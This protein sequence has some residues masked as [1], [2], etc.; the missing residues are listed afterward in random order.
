MFWVHDLEKKASV[1]SCMKLQTWRMKKAA[2]V[3]HAHGGAAIYI[4]S[5]RVLAVLRDQLAMSNVVSSPTAPLCMRRLKTPQRHGKYSCPVYRP[6]NRDS[7]NIAQFQKLSNRWRK[8]KDFDRQSR[9]SR[10]DV[11]SHEPDV[12]PNS[13]SVP[14]AQDRRRSDSS[15]LSVSREADSQRA[16]SR[17][18]SR[19]ESENGQ[20]GLSVVYT[21]PDE[22]RADIVFIHGLGGASR[23]TWSKN[24]DP[25]LFWPLKFLPFEPDIGQ[26]RIFTF[27]Y[28][29]NFRAAGKNG[30]SILDFAKDLLFDLK[31]TN[32]EQGGN[33]QIGDVSK[34]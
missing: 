17:S 24:G 1:P 11:K 32:T 33:L 9:F 5:L 30:L 4:S 27:G 8:E 34:L 12:S 15:F 13:L 18:P 29:A 22:R 25:D 21:P 2:A 16:S 19:D 6:R 10:D 3:G 28:N 31:Y 23:K 14:I 26:A 7:D 20:V